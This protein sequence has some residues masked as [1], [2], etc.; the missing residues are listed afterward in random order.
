MK[1]TGERQTLSTIFLI[2][3]SPVDRFMAR[4]ALEQEGFRVIE[5]DSGEAGLSACAEHLPDCVLLDVKMPRMNGFE[6][7]AALRATEHGTHL[8]VLMLT[9]LDDVDS[10]NRA[11][12]AGAT[13]FY[14]KPI[15]CAVLIHRVR[16]LLRAKQIQESA[17]DKS[18][19]AEAE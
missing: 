6:T 13:D 18:D 17:E 15:N 7:C 14:S 11:Y 5:C 19:G 12:E 8:P 9:G 10:I 4:E 3:D 2:D 16:Y 1:G